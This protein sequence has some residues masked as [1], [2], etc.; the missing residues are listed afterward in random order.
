MPLHGSVNFNSFTQL[1]LNILLYDIY[2][3][4]G[5]ISLNIFI[6]EEFALSND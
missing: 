6:G 1:G 3:L 4:L 2:A 5:F